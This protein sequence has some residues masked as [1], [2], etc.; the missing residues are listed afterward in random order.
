MKGELFFVNFSA[1]VVSGQKV[2]VRAPFLL[3]LYL[4]YALYNL[5]QIRFPL[6][7]FTFFR[8]LTAARRISLQAFLFAAPLRPY[9]LRRPFGTT[10]LY[11]GKKV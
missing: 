3:A 10:A 5:S 9:S 2:A 6:S 1:R 4:F 11:H 7:A 8:P